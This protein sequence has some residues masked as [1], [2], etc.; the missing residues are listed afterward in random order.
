MLHRNHRSF[1]ASRERLKESV[2]ALKTT[3][4]ALEDTRTRRSSDRELSELKGSI[5]EA[6][7]KAEPLMREPFT[8]EK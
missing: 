8:E 7:A 4:K 2:E 6:I 3:L 1:F 5:R